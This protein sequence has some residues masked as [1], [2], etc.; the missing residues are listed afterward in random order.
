MKR[1]ITLTLTDDEAG[2]LI[3]VIETDQ[4]DV[5]EDEKGALCRVH[6]V[7]HKLCG[8]EEE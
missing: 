1:T 8:W 7:I 6:A 5:S 2:A 4:R 3:R